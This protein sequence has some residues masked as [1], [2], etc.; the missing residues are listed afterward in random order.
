M[1]K[2]L[3]RLTANVSPLVLWETDTGAVIMTNDKP[4]KDEAPEEKNIKIVIAEITSDQG[5]EIIF[6]LR[7]P[8]SEEEIIVTPQRAKKIRSGEA[9]FPVKKE[10]FLE[11][12]P[13]GI[14]NFLFLMSRLEEF[15]KA[16]YKD[17]EPA[18]ERRAMSI[19]D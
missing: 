3:F 9:E 2:E 1:A 8:K 17:Y 13:D 10:R 18:M 4:G 5:R 12:W 16:R 6:T 11:L 19:L 7:H 15:L 14:A